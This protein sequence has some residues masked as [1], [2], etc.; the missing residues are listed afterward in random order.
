MLGRM[1]GWVGSGIRKMAVASSSLDCYLKDWVKGR[2]ASVAR[3]DDVDWE[4]PFVRCFVGIAEQ[5][6]W[7][8]CCGYSSGLMVVRVD[9]S[10]QAGVVEEAVAAVDAEVA[11]IAVAVAAAAAADA[12]VSRKGHWD[13]GLDSRKM[14]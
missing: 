1:T 12:A 2:I 11:G 9:P 6:E 10:S 8:C 14:R 4:V 3:F 7:V 5:R 13:L